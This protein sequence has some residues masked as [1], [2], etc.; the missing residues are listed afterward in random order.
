LHILKRTF[1]EMS[2]ISKSQQEISKDFVTPNVNDALQQARQVLTHG[3]VDPGPNE[4][5]LQESTSVKVSQNKQD[6]IEVVIRR[7]TVSHQ[8]TDDESEE[9]VSYSDSELYGPSVGALPRMGSQETLL[10]NHASHT[11][12]KYRRKHGECWR[13][14]DLAKDETDMRLKSKLM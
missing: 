11:N 8:N 12:A 3:S 5:L 7:S 4:R 1:K 10:G 13:K 14:A 2:S 6:K 9:F